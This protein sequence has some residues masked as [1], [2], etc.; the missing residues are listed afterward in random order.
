[1]SVRVLLRRGGLALLFGTGALVLALAFI[2]FVPPLRA[3]RQAEW[4][5]VPLV[6]PAQNAWQPYLGA[7]VDLAREPVPDWLV[8]ATDLPALSEEQL[9]Y[10]DRHPAAL[11]ALHAGT[12][13]PQARYFTQATTASTP[14]PH[15]RAVRGLA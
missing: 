4:P 2:A 1:M 5:A 13:R 7:L 10:L 15:P 14:L 11:R 12:Q 3:V 6:P 8:T 9:A